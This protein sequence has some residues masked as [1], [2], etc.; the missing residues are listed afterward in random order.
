MPKYKITYFN[1]TGRAEIARWMFALAGQDYEDHRVSR[2]DWQKIK[3]DTPFQ[4]VPILTV[5]DT[6]QFSQSL[7]IA[8][9]LAKRFG[10]MGK[11]EYEEARI[12][13][14]LECTEDMV[15]PLVKA[16]FYDDESKTGKEKWEGSER[17]SFLERFEKVLRKNNN[18]DGYFV[19][20]G[21]SVADIWFCIVSDYF[22]DEESLDWSKYPKLAA[23]RERVEKGNKQIAEWIAKRPKGDF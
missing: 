13:M 16:I 20:D 15:K 14:I 10:F 21:I 1:G 9:F 3:A 6:F 17:S 12:N 5:D 4:Q 7:A 2:E 23:L 8:K 18:G 11:D 22:A 19:G